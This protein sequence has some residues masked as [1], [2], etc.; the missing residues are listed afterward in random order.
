MYNEDNSETSNRKRPPPSADKAKTEIQY[1]TDRE[2]RKRAKTVNP[3]PAS[4]STSSIPFK[5]STKL[6]NHIP[7][8]SDFVSIRLPNNQ[9]RYCKILPDAEY[10]EIS[11]RSR[12]HFISDTDLAD[13]VQDA[14]K[15]NSNK[16]HIPMEFDD[17]TSLKDVPPLE[18]KENLWVRKYAPKSYIQLVSAET[19]NRSLLRWMKSWD[20]YVFGQPLP[21][22]QMPTEDIMQKQGTA[23]EAISQIDP[24]DRRP[25]FKLVLISGPP[26][27]GK[28]TLAHLVAKQAGY[29]VL[30]INA[31]DDR[32]PDVLIDRINTAANSAGCLGSNLKP[33]CLVIDEID[34]ALSSTVDVLAEAA[35]TMPHEGQKAK[36]SKKRS[37]LLRRPIICICNDLYAKALKPLRAPNVPCLMLK[38]P[39]I[40][41]ST[42]LARLNRITELEGFG[43]MDRGVLAALIDFCDRDLRACINA[44]QFLLRNKKGG[45]P[46]TLQDLQSSINSLGFFKDNRSSLLQALKSIFTIPL[47][48]QKMTHSQNV[49]SRL[50]QVQHV[51]ESSGDQQTVASGIF[52]NYLNARLRDS[53]FSIATEAADW[54]CFQDLIWKKIHTNQRYDLQ[55][56]S[57]QIPLWFN[58]SMA[59]HQGITKTVRGQT[60]T[61]RTWTNQASNI[62]WPVSDKN[63][64]QELSK[65]NS[66]LD[67]LMANQWSVTDC[68]KTDLRLLQKRTF[69]LDAAPH[70]IKYLEKSNSLL[71]PVNLQLY[72]KDEKELLYALVD[73][74]LILGLQWKPDHS[75]IDVSNCI[76]FELDPPLDKIVR[77]DFPKK[78]KDEEEQQIGTVEKPRMA[79]VPQSLRQII[80]REIQLK[81]MKRANQVDETHFTGKAPVITD[82]KE[83]HS[84]EALAALNGNL[85]QEVIKPKR[86]FFGRI[87]E[88]KKPSKDKAVT[89]PVVASVTNESVFFQFNEGFSCAVRRPVTMARFM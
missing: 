26:G 35:K 50:L 12:S 15:L 44:L 28:T 10:Q 78:S 58:M 61:G 43:Q 73:K 86:D 49:K 29:E 89:N 83:A 8:L 40:E 53:S 19:T 55:K 72:T 38:M 20:H 33:C 14:I 68:A 65:N 88:L 80:S 2:P 56:Y 1:S 47:S 36:K 16:K 3:E 42:L 6:L 63:C 76:N 18:E 70:L 62:L 77:M 46:L 32:S 57:A 41:Q 22:E 67:L 9:R 69:A 34:G 71:R 74:F 81:M 11:C 59:T 30:E 39:I 60:K 17:E 23:D 31:S 21:R 7:E 5:K 24:R 84:K 79:K 45:D 25:M 87:I 66:I 37:L 13:L 4:S 82:V 27:L 75:S 64:A 85:K 48:S 51:C 54:L 52:E